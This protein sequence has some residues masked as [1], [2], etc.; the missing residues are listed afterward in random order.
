M[1]GGVGL[2]CLLG[3]A[4]PGVVYGFTSDFVK[5][6]PDLVELLFQP[7]KYPISKE[8]FIRQFNATLECN[9]FDRLQ[10]IKA[11]TLVLHGKK[12]VAVTPENGSILAEAI[13]NAKLVYFEKSAHGLCEEMNEVINSI[14]DFLV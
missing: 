4:D 6:H 5:E 11:Q 1:Q 8:A 12:D 14:A 9:T 10:Q 7:E 3:P 2:C 13:P